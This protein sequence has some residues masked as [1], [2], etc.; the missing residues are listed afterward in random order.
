MM[1]RGFSV[2]FV[3]LALFLVGIF[4]VE[5]FSNVSGLPRP[6]GPVPVVVETPAPCV[7]D[8]CVSGGG[9][10]TISYS[11][12]CT[13][14]DVGSSDIFVNGNVT[15][16]NLNLSSVNIWKDVCLP[17]GRLRENY[18]HLPN[19]DSP[20]TTYVNCSQI[21]GYSCVGGNTSGRCDYTSIKTYFVK[22][23]SGGLGGH[24]QRGLFVL[25][26]ANGEVEWELACD[27]TL[28]SCSSPLLGG[29]IL[30]PFTGGSFVDC[31]NLTP[32]YP[33]GVYF[34]EIHIL[35]GTYV[36]LPSQSGGN[37][38]VYNSNGLQSTFS[39]EPNTKFVVLDNGNV[40]IVP[41]S[42]EQSAGH[43]VV[44]GGSSLNLCQE[45]I[46]TIT[47]RRYG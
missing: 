20:W 47:T 3:F 28:T 10:S 4:F 12:N 27:Y 13:D 44:S 43:I 39:P 18:C 34:N 31:V 32:L 36:V 14:S 2:F 38:L 46:G 1:K 19:S 9:G 41:R 22:W 42:N 26:S 17:D 5:N 30:Q 11:Y 15:V 16:R 40:G 6:R 29:V 24:I 37:I 23:G 8:D 35:G 25:N 45:N 21:G 7:G 33:N